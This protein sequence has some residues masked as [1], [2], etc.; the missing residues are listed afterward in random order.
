MKLKNRPIGKASAFWVFFL[1]F[2]GKG[3]I[4]LS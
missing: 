4:Y 3:G 2:G 1:V